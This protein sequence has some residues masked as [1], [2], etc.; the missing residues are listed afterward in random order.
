MAAPKRIG[1]V[2]DIKVDSQTARQLSQVEREL[3]GVNNQL[4]E[5]KKA[6]NTEVYGKLKVQQ[7]GLRFEAVK[8]RKA[9]RD[10]VKTFETAKFPKDSL[11]GLRQEYGK[12]I[13]EIQTLSKEERKGDYAKG[14]IKN[15][16]NIKDEIDKVEQ[17]FGKFN[18]NVGNYRD[19]LISIGDI[20]TGGLLTGGISAIASKVGEILKDAFATIRAFEQGL[21]D[22]QALTGLV[23]QDL[24][25]LGDN[26]VDL[27]RKFGIS[28]T[29]ILDGFKLVGSAKP[30][31][32]GSAEALSS[33]TEQAIILSKASG[34]E[35]AESVDVITKGLNAYGLSADKAADFT[36]ILAAS[37]QK[38]TSPIKNLNQAL[39]QVVPVTA[40]ANINFEETNALL[41]GLAK[42]GFEG[43]RAGTALRNIITI[44]AST[45]RKE[46]NPTY[47]EFSDILE[48]LSDEITDV[49]A[50]EELFGRENAAAALSLISQRDVVRQLNGALNEQGAALEQAGI[51]MDNVDGKVARLS[52]TWDAFVLSV[53]KGDG[54]IS[55][56]VGNILDSFTGLAALATET[57]EG[58][59]TFF[60]GLR[61]LFT[62]PTEIEDYIASVKKV[63]EIPKDFKGRGIPGADTVEKQIEFTRAQIENLKKRLSE[64]SEGSAEYALTVEDINTAQKRLDAL[65]LS[66]KSNAE[67]TK[68]TYDQL[69]A[70]QSKL[71]SSIQDL[72]ASG[73]D[74]SKQLREYVKVTKEV[75]AVNKIFEKQ[76][77]ET[78]QAQENS[79]A[80]LKK[81]ISE[82]SKEIESKNLG[83]SEIEKRLALIIEKEKG[84]QSL[85]GNLAKIRRSLERPLPQ[86]EL[87][88]TIT[89]AAKVNTN[90][91]ASNENRLREELSNIERVQQERIKAAN[92]TI[93][94]ENDLEEEKR[95]INVQ[96]EIDAIEA[97]LDY[98]KLSFSERLSLENQLFDKKKELNQKE[99]E[100]ERRK[101][102]EIKELAKAAYEQI[103]QF[104]LQGIENEKEALKERTDQQLA[105]IQTEYEARILGAEGNAAEQQRLRKEQGEKEKAIEKEAAKQRKAIAKKEALI[106][107]ALA[108][109]KAAPNPLL[110]AFAA[111]TTAVN[112]GQIESQSFFAGGRI[113]TQDGAVLPFPD[114][115]PEIG[116]GRV[117]QQPN[118][119]TTPRGDNVLATIRNGEAVLNQQQIRLGEL[120]Y[121]KKFLANIGVPGF[122][123]GGLIGQTPQ[124]TNPRL[125]IQ[126]SL[127]MQQ[128][129]VQASI[130]PESIREMAR[131]TAEAI[132]VSAKDGIIEAEN[133]KQRNER[134]KD[135][136]A[137]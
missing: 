95:R 47:N 128:I 85:E 74:Y 43:A 69:V 17:S 77:K 5:A 78:V 19:G 120:A 117:T 108:I 60:Q 54:V 122:A 129:E 135:N 38:G 2:L 63:L 114:N 111:L 22:L 81:D 116:P 21:D 72:A 106:Q 112:V 11:L 96:A 71:K 87:L 27:G 137:A 15:A 91:E 70:R 100:E 126:R 104:A 48:V 118:I 23:G 40:K 51:R 29:E 30:E 110:M 35:L 124:I 94:K 13:K 136:Q 133:I 134:A 46:L 32:L 88:Q 79:I 109:I 125:A 34:V 26:A 31:L 99:I 131:Q 127:T 105:D 6:G 52:A 7:Q 8:L 16:K 4:R 39:L 68:T 3:L 119:P 93:S 66:T 53:D 83:Q 44:L 61:A 64:L 42:G 76:S 9:L 55:K 28:A 115:I 102:D 36:D 84:I 86:V 67:D 41:Q 98:A 123:T 33:V 107:G 92:E 49:T 58:N 62:D 14:L 82:L 37:Q 73:G 12:L 20:V 101:Q 24:D 80:A 89:P 90:P 59:L 25:T 45:G 10:Q 113:K 103:F 65:L 121:G 18:S 75:N 132:K 57:N 56:A 130:S 1:L 50:A 97:K